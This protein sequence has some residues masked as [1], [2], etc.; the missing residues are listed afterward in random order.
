LPIFLRATHLGAAD[1]IAGLPLLETLADN[2]GIVFAVCGVILA[3][4]GF[5]TQ[6]R[7]V[8]EKQ[9]LFAFALTING[10]STT[11]YAAAFCLAYFPFRALA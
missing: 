1:I 10:I 11:V 8:R 7:I 2:R 6:F 3:F 9:K 4:A 5:L